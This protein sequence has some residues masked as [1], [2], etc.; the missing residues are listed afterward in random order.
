MDSGSLLDLV[1][2]IDLGSLI[3]PLALLDGLIGAV[4]AA[5][6]NIIDV[7]PAGSS[8]VAGSLNEILGSVGDLGPVEAP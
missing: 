1:S 6:G 5:V 4:F 7:L 2:S 8:A 3:D